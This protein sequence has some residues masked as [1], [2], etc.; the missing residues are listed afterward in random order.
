MNHF[1]NNP[2]DDPGDTFDDLKWDLPT[3]SLVHMYNDNYDYKVR[4][5]SSLAKLV[6]T[7]HEITRLCKQLEKDLNKVA[8]QDLLNKIYLFLSIHLDGNYLLGEIPAG[9]LF[10]GIN[11]PRGRHLGPYV[12]I[13]PDKNLRAAYRD[14]LLTIEP[15]TDKF[16]DL[17]IH[18]LAHTGCNHVRW[19]PDDHGP[20]FQ[21]FE[22]LLKNVSRKINFLGDY[23]NIN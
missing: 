11:L 20:D 2:N 7:R 6:Y 19:R 17:L 5:R 23:K 18:E 15:Q 8:S 1:T 3:T 13:G 14:I 21:Q 9:T 10:H 4:S 16:R 22:S 12:H